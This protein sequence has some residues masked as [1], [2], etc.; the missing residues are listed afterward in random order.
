MT[1]IKWWDLAFGAFLPVLAFLDWISYSPSEA[2]RI[3][4]W[5]TLAALAA[6][7]LG[8]GRRAI[9]DQRHPLAFV[10][11]LIVACPLLTAFSPSL[12]VV[13]ALAIP[14][15]WWLTPKIGSA[16]PLTVV[17][18][19]AVFIGWLVALGLSP[20]ALV[21]A[22]V[23]QGLAL[24]F[25]IAFGVWISWIAAYG[26]DRARLL[27]ELT[28]AQDQLAAQ[29]RDAGVASERERLS[30]EIHD[31]IAQS[32]TSL[33]LL[34]QRTRAELDQ[35]P[36]ETEAAID[37][38][39]LIESTAR[40]ALTETRS[41]V[42]VLAPLPALESGLAD[43][44]RRL[45]ARFER[46]TGVRVTIAIDVSAV[47]RDLEVV[48]LRCV[49]EGLAN[50][51]KHADAA[52][53]SIRLDEQH[54]G[55]RLHLSDDGRGIGEQA[56]RSSGGFG[57]AGMRDRLAMVGG[58]LTVDRAHTGGTTLLVTIPLKEEP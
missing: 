43:V 2:A 14:C 4:A 13:Q 18:V 33:V 28:A 15:L 34:A 37:S 25:S 17:L 5:V 10:L 46:E 3:G 50:V 56:E 16:I 7:Y 48:L 11:V 49:Q 12:A 30:R 27:D 9:R 42:A 26:D 51:R 38:V 58:T 55:L 40:D 39:E 31:T 24:A 36:G 35:L 47:P 45:G 8:F 6:C 52:A 41:L 32:L 20:D 29:H 44:L 23:T 57:L 1:R 22:I 53:V 21:Q 19:V 54:G